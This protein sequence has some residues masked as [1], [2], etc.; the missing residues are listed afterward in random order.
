MF[1]MLTLQ[2]LLSLRRWALI[3]TAKQFTSWSTALQPW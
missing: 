1:A 2:V 3:T